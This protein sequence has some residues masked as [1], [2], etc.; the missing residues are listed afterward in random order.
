MYQTDINNEDQDVGEDKE[1]VTLTDWENPPTLADLKQDYTDA[2]SDQDLQVSKIDTWLDNLNVRGA[3]KIKKVTGRSSIVPKLIRKQAEWRYAA[4][5]EPFLS[6]EDVFNVAPVTFEDKAAAKQNELVLNNQFNTKLSKVKFIDEYVR[7]AVDEGTVIVRVG[8]EFHEEEKEVEVPQFDFVPSTDP[9]YLGFLE[10]IGKLAQ[11]DPQ[12]FSTQ[13]QPEMQEALRRSMATGQPVQPINTGSTLETQTVTVRNQPTLDICSYKNIIVDPSCEGD[14]QKAGFIIYSF[15]TSLSELEKEGKYENLDNINVETNSVLS[16]P[17]HASENEGSF[18]FNDKPRKKFV[19]Y[20]YWGYWD[21]DNSGVVSPIIAT[22]VGD[23]LIRLQENPF[24]D[25]E[26]PFVSAQYLPVRKSIFGEPD[27]ELL[28]DNQKVVGAVTRGMIDIMGRSANGQVITQKGALDDTNKRKF[29]KGLDCESNGTTPPEQIATVLSYPEIPRSAEYML[30]M[31]NAE[32]ESMSGVKA[33][34]QGITGAALGNTVG[35]QKNALDATAKRELGILR[36]LAEGMKQVGRKIISMN[37]EFLEEE[38][39]VRVTNEEFVPVR[40]DDLAGKFDLTLTISTAEAD[41]QKAEELAF[42]LQ[43]MGNNMDA[44]MSKMILSDIANLRKMP[45]LAK[46]IEE[47]E[48]TPDPLAQKK[49]ELEIALIEAQVQKEQSMAAENMAN[50]QLY[51][52][53]VLTEQAK[54][55]SL[56]SNADKVDLDF[57]EQESGT[58]QERALQKMNVQTEGNIALKVAEKRLNVDNKDK[59]A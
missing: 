14:I 58:T 49:M 59:T 4:L 55:K 9:N 52:A 19:A 34:S 42:M 13:V 51:Q 45:A 26:L 53:R 5:T 2:R 39:V 37:S 50:A 44:N 18:S 7:T 3:A 24:P 6:T 12:G 43:T 32:A 38:E 20:E 17:D 28:E 46:K 41:N 1:G 15:D 47:F 25:Q 33:F 10:N 22:W 11:S 29:D 48:P 31:Q 16:E 40:R 23:T 36:R 30:N 21:I 54:A 57:V 35:G 56:S 27:G 8:W